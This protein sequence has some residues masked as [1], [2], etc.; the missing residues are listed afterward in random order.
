MRSA[1]VFFLFILSLSPVMAFAFELKLDS[2]G[3]SEFQK[4]KVLEFIDQTSKL[5]PY[6][7]KT[8]LNKTLIVKFENISE[9]GHTRV[10]SANVTLSNQLLP[11]I[12][13]GRERSLRTIK[14]ATHHKN[15]Y[16]IAVGTLIH[17]IAHQYDFYH[18]ER[19]FN[20][21]DQER[22]LCLE[23]R[24]S[25]Q[26]N[27]ISSG[28][29]KT[30][31]P[32]SCF[33]KSHFLNVSDNPKFA[34]SIGWEQKDIVN[35]FIENVDDQI[36]RSPYPYEFSSLAEAFAVNMEFFLLD[37]Q[38]KCRRP[39]VYRLLSQHFESVPHPNY[40]CDSGNYVLVTYGSPTDSGSAYEKIDIRRVYQI[41]YL[42][43]GEGSV[44]M[45]KWGHSML[46]LVVC[47]PFRKQVGPECM[48]DLAYHKVVSYRAGV[49]D[50]A[51][52]SIKGL[53]GKYPSQIFV[54]PLL[55][56]FNE[57]S[58]G[59][60]RDIYSYPLNLNANEIEDFLTRVIEQH[61]SYRG[62]YYFISNNCAVETLN[63]LKHVKSENHSFVSQ[64]A[65]TPYGV[66]NLLLKTGYAQN[67]S[68]D[69]IKSGLYFEPSKKNFFREHLGKVNQ[70]TGLNIRDVESFMN[71]SENLD[72]ET[73]DQ[74]RKSHNALSSFYIL[75][76]QKLSNLTVK[77]NYLILENE[78]NQK[79]SVLVKLIKQKVSDI[80]GGESISLAKSYGVPMNNEVEKLVERLSTKSAQEA[81]KE[82]DQL[83]LR[84][85]EVCQGILGEELINSLNSLEDILKET[86]KLLRERKYINNVQKE[87]L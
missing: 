9:A 1:V 5:L 53:T 57:Y 38:F 21:E 39:T 81:I 42:L 84:E 43:A 65:T 33:W 82:R 37:P 13:L 23:L 48:Q 51:I 6:S 61:W 7:L 22:R 35:G 85:I 8:R 80:M 49:T 69:M 46:R 50:L 27:V 77:K 18:I 47:A 40:S 55:N 70:A 59:E 86:K 56:V 75:A 20:L 45:S 68:K 87:N 76:Q 30:A 14:A 25:S 71:Q 36:R 26:A 19:P 60:L 4:V 31:I 2:S 3:L 29:Q 63:L 67:I 52:S 73:F 16:D 83:L 58:K 11:A 72:R 74:V 66:L 64:G 54:L 78:R 34:Y 44:M 79:D 32:E 28:E 15:D 62:R 10:N 17:E 24:L 12:V 41:H